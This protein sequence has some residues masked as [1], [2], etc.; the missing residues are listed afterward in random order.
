MKRSIIIVL[1]I[2]LYI[3]MFIIINRLLILADLAINFLLIIK[4]YYT[5]EGRIIDLK[6]KKLSSVISNEMAHTES[7]ICMDDNILCGSEF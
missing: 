1:H 4:T 7:N 6:K 5:A 2:L 3:Q